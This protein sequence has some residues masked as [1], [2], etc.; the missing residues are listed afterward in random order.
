M[1]IKSGKI[2]NIFGVCFSSKSLF[3][4]FKNKD[5]AILFYFDLYKKRYRDFLENLDIII[6][7]DDEKIICENDVVFLDN[8][9]FNKLVLVNY[10]LQIKT[11]KNAISSQNISKYY[12]LF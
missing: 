9:F 11:K 2:E 7:I 3:L 1:N 12:V 5:I 10:D 6:G 8:K 4:R